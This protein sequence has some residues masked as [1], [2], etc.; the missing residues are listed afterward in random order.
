MTPSPFSKTA[1][2]PPPKGVSVKEWDRMLQKGP[3]KSMTKSAAERIREILQKEAFD[4]VTSPAPLRAD[5]VIDR[6]KLS[7]VADPE[8]L[9]VA[10]V[11]APDCDEVGLGP[12]LQTY[13][14][15]GGVYKHAFG[16]PMFDTKQMAGSPAVSGG[17]AARASTPAPRMQQSPVSVT[18]TTLGQ[19]SGQPGGASAPSQASTPSAPT[20]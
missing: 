13:E 15:L 11:L 6:E 9:K 17:M 7:H 19:G 8:L 2:P 4:E 18:T 3:S 14:E 12:L 16:Q 20:G 10:Y 1:E 5:E